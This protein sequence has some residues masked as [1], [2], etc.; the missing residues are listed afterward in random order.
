[1]KTKPSTTEKYEE[2]SIELARLTSD[3]L[4]AEKHNLSGHID[5]DKHL[6]L[7]GL[8]EELLDQDILSNLNLEQLVHAADV[9]DIVYEIKHTDL[10][11]YLNSKN[12]KMSKKCKLL[13]DK[14]NENQS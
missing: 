8:I 6:Y 1:M 3:F 12:K 5:I 4:D 11:K 13:K 7:L 10:K 9:F 14:K 2:Y